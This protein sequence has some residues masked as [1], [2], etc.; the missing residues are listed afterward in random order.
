MGASRLQDGIDNAVRAQSRG[1]SISQ[2]NEEKEK[3]MKAGGM[4]GS[5]EGEKAAKQVEEV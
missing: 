2:Y 3:M 4:E 1:L 5:D